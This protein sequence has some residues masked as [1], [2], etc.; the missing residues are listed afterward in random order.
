MMAAGGGKLWGTVIVK[1]AAYIPVLTD[2]AC[3][4]DS[5]LHTDQP[6]AYD[7]QTYEAEGGSGVNEIKDRC[8]NRH[9]KHING[10]FADWSARKIGLKELWELWWHY[11]WNPNNDPPP[12]FCTVT[13][14][15]DG[16][17]CY[18]KDYYVP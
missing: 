17:M 4:E 9:I 12:D 15:Y 8:I 1:G 3:E 2:S 11:D 5:P 7:G 6:P 10:V 16:W 14:N 13:A 18:M